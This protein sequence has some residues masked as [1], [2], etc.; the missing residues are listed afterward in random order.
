MRSSLTRIREEFDKFR[1]TVDG[2]PNMSAR[3]LFYKFGLHLVE[4]YKPKQ[5]SV[6]E[7]ANYLGVSRE[8]ARQLCISG[9]LH[10]RQEGT[11]WIIDEPD[12]RACAKVERKVGRP[13]SVSV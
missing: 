11:S 9:D 13:R 7:A 5:Y 6:L 12:L 4:K 8:R 3:D 10:A 1:P 2:W